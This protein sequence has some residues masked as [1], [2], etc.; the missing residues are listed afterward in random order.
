MCKF[1]FWES[2]SETDFNQIPS[3]NVA[4]LIYLCYHRMILA[5]EKI[6]TS[7]QFGLW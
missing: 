3:G 6:L 7:V 4:K 5:D 2:K 1:S